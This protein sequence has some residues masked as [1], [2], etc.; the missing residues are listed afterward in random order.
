MMTSTQIFAYARCRSC[1]ENS[2]TYFRWTI[3]ILLYYKYENTQRDRYH[4]T[5]SSRKQAQVNP[6]NETT[7]ATDNANIF[8]MNNIQ[9][10]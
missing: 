5:K 7:D 2:K 4:I 1:K 6:I 3:T 10:K 8:R 9:F